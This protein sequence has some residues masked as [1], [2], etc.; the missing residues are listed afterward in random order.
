MRVASSLVA[1]FVLVLVV[2]GGTTRVEAAAQT[3]TVTTTG[4]ATGLC[5]TPSTCVSL[6]QAI[7]SANAN[8]GADTIVF[9]I[10]GSGVHVIE[11]L[12]LPPITEAVTINGFC[13]TCDGA[14]A[15]S[16][17][18]FSPINAVYRIV[19][20]GPGGTTD[21]L[22]IDSPTAVT[23]RGLNIRNYGGSGITIKQGTAHVIAGNY[24][25]T[26]ETGTAKS[27]MNGG[28]I[29]IQGTT[30]NVT[31][32]GG[33][34]ADRNLLSGGGGNAIANATVGTVAAGLHVF[35]NYVGTNA[36]GNAAIANA[37]TAILTVS[38]AL[39]VGSTTA[40]T[41]N[42]ISGNLGIGVQVVPPATG[43]I[44]GNRIGTD[45]AGNAALGNSRG[46]LVQS[47]VSVGGTAAGAGNLISANINEGVDINGTSSID[48]LGNTFGTNAAGTAALPNGGKQIRVLDSNAVDIGG[49]VANS[50]NRFGGNKVSAG[51]GLGISIEGSSSEVRVLNN[52]I[53][54]GSGGQAL[55]HKSHGIVSESSGN[56]LTILG[57]TVVAG[58]GDG[59]R[60]LPQV[61]VSGLTIT[62]NFVGETS[63][64]SF[65][66]NS[67][68]GV[69]IGRATGVLGGSAPGAANV[70]AHNG[71][72][73]VNLI[74]DTAQVTMSRNRVFA[75]GTDPG[76]V[77][78]DLEGDGPSDPDNDDADTGANGRLNNLE[79]TGKIYADG[80][81]VFV[82]A[83]YR[84]VAN[85]QFTAEL[86]R[87]TD[88]QSFGSQ[89]KF[90]LSDVAVATGQNGF[91]QQ[92]IEVQ[93][94]AVGEYFA[95][96]MLDGQ[97]NSSEFS[98][99]F[100][101][102]CNQV[103]RAPQ[104][105]DCD[106]DITAVDALAVLNRLA[107]IGTGPQAEECS[108]DPAL[109]PGDAD[110]DGTET[111]ED[112]MAIRRYLAGLEDIFG[113]AVTT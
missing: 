11:E 88:C 89:G 111:L 2:A 101:N 17:G 91:G 28:L 39:Q 70:I 46:V 12:S 62:G 21:G 34:N 18:L 67:G 38:T 45:A 90:Y 37:G 6:R 54:L 112:V 85:A 23:I 24:I 56:D 30:S 105:V 96:L 20:D 97:G 48:V 10:A 86:Y 29:K 103:L 9:D 79:I 51:T 26:N 94:L 100:P 52:A 57:N 72:D 106:F 99:G 93:G 68:T 107:E 83:Q 43:S 76:E 42:V 33:S 109:S 71:D 27:G 95:A 15:N 65:Q 22:I 78:I 19:L 25:G 5:P 63:T 87:N 58:G 13:A 3:Y 4:T 73:G 50:G 31:V 110:G 32:G 104:D 81:R 55:G 80:D 47:Q 74:F 35:G 36:A 60:V 64:G 102:G 40:G 77:G 53:G 49:F 1:A 44:Q 8:A 41:G 82:P 66:G 108:V 61:P 59:I 113:N 75:N 14:A 16:A 84:N 98:R 7:A 92:V 69:L